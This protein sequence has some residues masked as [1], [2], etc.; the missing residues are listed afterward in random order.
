VARFQ[1][2]VDARDAVA[3]SEFWQTALGYAAEPPPPGYASW[4]EFAE[5]HGIPR[6]QWRSS[7]VDPDGVLP[8][9]FFQ[10]VPEPKSVKNRVHLDITASDP[11]APPEQRRVAVDADVRRLTEAGATAVRTVDSWEGYWVVMQD[12]EGNEFCVQ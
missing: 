3:L 11:A 10:P 6:E 2:V 8:R 4:P 5:R 7:A 1:I 9:L 12:P